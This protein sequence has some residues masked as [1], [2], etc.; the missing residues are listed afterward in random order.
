MA[1]RLGSKSLLLDACIVPVSVPVC[2]LDFRQLQQ[3][4]MTNQVQPHQVQQYQQ[5]N[6]PH[7]A[8]QQANNY[9]SNQYG[10][11]LPPNQSGLM[12]PQGPHQPGQMPP[13]MQQQVSAHYFLE[14]NCSLS[15]SSIIS[16]PLKPV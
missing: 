15:L 2:H 9:T 16:S 1:A 11:G 6:S 4:L 12:G 14:K 3:P 7:L 5:N 8:Y 10:Q 13:H